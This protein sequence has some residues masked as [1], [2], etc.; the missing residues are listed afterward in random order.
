MEGI[1]AGDV[2]GTVQGTQ[3]SSVCFSYYY[4]LSELI[5]NGLDCW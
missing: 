4:L 3:M 1:N 5:L 2:Y